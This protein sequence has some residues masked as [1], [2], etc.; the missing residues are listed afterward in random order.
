MANDIIDN[1]LNAVK[2]EKVLNLS[3]TRD[4]IWK[5]STT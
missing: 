2:D 1:R 5:L 3:L 4:L